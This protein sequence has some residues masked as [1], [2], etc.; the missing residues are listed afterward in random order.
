MGSPPSGGLVQVHCYVPI[1]K[2]DAWHFTSI[3]DWQIG[4]PSHIN[5]GLHEETHAETSYNFYLYKDYTIDLAF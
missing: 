1:Y 2:P 4:L 3:Q 5:R